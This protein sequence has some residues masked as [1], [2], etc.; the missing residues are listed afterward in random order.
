[1]FCT[2]S[3][4]TDS[5]FSCNCGYR[6]KHREEK[7]LKDY[8]GVKMEHLPFRDSPTV[9]VWFKHIPAQFFSCRSF[10]CLHTIKDMFESHTYALRLQTHENG[11]IF[12]FYSENFQIGFT[13]DASNRR[14]S[15]AIQ[16]I[17]IA[18]FICANLPFSCSGFQEV[19]QGWRQ[20]GL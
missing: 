6:M 10:A 5:L 20:H 2:I 19:T 17:W 1:M 12:H 8:L 16:S 7:R 13:L 14:C 3:L 11:Y 15:T 9:D 4:W 18:K